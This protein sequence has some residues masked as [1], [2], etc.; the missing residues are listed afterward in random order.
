MSNQFFSENDAYKFLTVE[1]YFDRY[2]EWERLGE[3][4]SHEFDADLKTL[5]LNFSKSD[6][7]PCSMLIQFPQKDTFRL[8][9]NPGKKA[10][11]YPEEN[12]PSV[13]LNTFTDLT[14]LLDQ[15]E[16][17]EIDVTYTSNSIQLVTK[18]QDDDTNDRREMKVVV[19]YKPFSITVSKF[20][21]HEE[22]IVWQ[23]AGTAIYFTPNGNED[24]AIIQAVKKPPNAKYVGFGE[25]GGQSLSKNTAQVNYFNFDNMRY[26]QVYNR[27]PL[28]PR[29]PLYRKTGSKAPSF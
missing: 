29:E 28:D 2:K 26:R 5:T 17:F 6:G 11:D 23:T 18:P 21:P 12:S 13:I 19:N 1:Q 15:R 9:F 7:N 14:R 24:Y 25:Q 8:R 10:E 27:G 16:H 4:K 20:A 3:V 22:Y